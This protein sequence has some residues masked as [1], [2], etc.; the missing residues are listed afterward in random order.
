MKVLYLIVARGGSKSIPGKNLQTIAGLSLVGF[1]AR[2]ARKAKTC[3]RLIISTDS[4]EIQEEARRHG[5]EVP[6]TRPAHLA[7][8]TAGSVDV[9]AHAM[10]WIEAQGE[11]YDALMLL[12]PSSPFATAADFDGAVALMERTGAAVVVGMREMEVNSIFTGAIDP[13]GRISTI[14]EKIAGRTALARQQMQQEFT[15]NGGLYLIAWEHF[16]RTGAIYSD[17]ARTFGYRMER[18]RSV[19]IDEPVDLD[20]ARFLVERGHIAMNHWTLTEAASNQ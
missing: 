2:A 16:R 12:E 13:A 10:D 15:M 18:H 19:E 14:V 3:S 11:Q 9:V 4:P 7:T 17:A 20:W 6:F 5:V 1:K 8:D